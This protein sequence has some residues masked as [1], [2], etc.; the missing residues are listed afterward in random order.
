[1]K[2]TSVEIGVVGRDSPFRLLTV[3]EITGHLKEVEENKMD[4]EA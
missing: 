1:M 2:A 4:I 3:A